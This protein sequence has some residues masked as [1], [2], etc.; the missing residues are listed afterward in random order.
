LSVAPQEV[1]PFYDV[2]RE[3]SGISHTATNVSDRLNTD[4][5]INVGAEGRDACNTAFFFD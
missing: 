3:Q 2:N 4:R 1:R 5:I